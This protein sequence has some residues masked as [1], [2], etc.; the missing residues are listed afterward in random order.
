LLEA[1]KF[2]N[3]TEENYKGRHLIYLLEG[4]AFD[5]LEL[6]E[7]LCDEVTGQIPEEELINLLFYDIPPVNLPGDEFQNLIGPV[8]YKAY[9]NYTYGVLVEEALIE[10]VME[11]VR[12]EK[13]SLGSNKDDG[14]ADRAYK[15]I[16]GATE[17]AMLGQFIRTK[18]YER[19]RNIYLSDMKEFMY[20]LFKYRVK[21][22]D[23]SRVAS[24]T[25]KALVFIQKT[26]PLKKKKLS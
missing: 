9:L 20:W 11:E 4:E 8:K 24:D 22:S 14:V 15:R 6:A 23:S 17:E 16:Y 13:R 18:G 26:M 12:K 7:R 19:R 2:W 10:A 25:R 1:I 21:N 5:W 3:S